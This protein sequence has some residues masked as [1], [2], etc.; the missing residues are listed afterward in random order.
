MRRFFLSLVLATALSAC[1]STA[2]EDAVESE[3]VTTFASKTEDQ[4]SAAIAKNVRASGSV[5]LVSVNLR[6]SIRAQARLSSSDRPDIEKHPDQ[7]PHCPLQ[8][9]Q[10][11]AA[12][13]AGSYGREWPQTSGHPEYFEALDRIVSR[14]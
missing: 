4:K 14:A 3:D 9:S 7:Y 10:N 6:E 12:N 11:C 5:A 1:A 13:S 2:I 8:L